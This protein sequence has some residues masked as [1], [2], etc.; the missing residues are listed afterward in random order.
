MCVCVYLKRERE[1]SE[2]LASYQKSINLFHM[3]EIF[4]KNRNLLGYKVNHKNF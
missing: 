3:Y 4:P 1:K 2:K